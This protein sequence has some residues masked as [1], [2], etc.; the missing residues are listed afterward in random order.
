MVY[1]KFAQNRSS[2]SSFISLFHFIRS[3]AR[4]EPLVIYNGTINFPRAYNDAKQRK[5]LLLYKTLTLF[6][7]GTLILHKTISLCIVLLCIVLF[8]MLKFS[9]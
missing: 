9:L 1:V 8:V 7:L 5:P 2:G 3:E 4:T 6:Y